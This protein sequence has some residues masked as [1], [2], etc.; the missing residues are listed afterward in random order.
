MERVFLLFFLAFRIVGLPKGSFLGRSE[1]TLVISLASR[2]HMLVLVIDRRPWLNCPWFCCHCF[3]CLQEI[4]RFRLHHQL[5]TS[6]RT[7]T[8]IYRY[9]RIKLLPWRYF[10]LYFLLVLVLDLVLGAKH[11]ILVFFTIRL[12]CRFVPI[13]HLSTVRILEAFW[14]A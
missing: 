9:N 2:T 6:S 11:H 12:R 10:C 8:D 14:I 3:V 7:T 4:G 1:Y 13:L 5:G